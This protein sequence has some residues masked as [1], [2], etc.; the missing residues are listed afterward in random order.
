MEKTNTRIEPVHKTVS[1]T[2]SVERAFEVFTERI[3]EWWPLELHSV[4]TEILGIK[5][6]S[7]AFVGREGGW[8]VE[9]MEGGR[10]APWAEILAWEPPHRL[11]LAWKPNPDRPAPTEI[12]VTFTAEPSGGTRV[13]LEHRGWERLGEEGRELKEGYSDWDGVLA[14]FA[15]LADRG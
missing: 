5:P 3:G 10:E 9:R 11:V 7:V 13:D 1:V 15:D 14:G 4:G 6:E 2:V 8:L 12:E